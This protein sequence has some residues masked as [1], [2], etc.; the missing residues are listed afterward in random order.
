MA[1]APATLGALL[2]RAREILAAQG[3]DD[4]ALDARLIVE[5]FSGT[6]RADA[7]ARPEQALDTA[8]T[9]AI[10]AAIAR[11]RR[12]EPVHR[13]LG[14]REFY[15]LK[16][17]LSPATLEPRPDTET[18]VD[19]VLPFLRDTARRE[20][21]CRIL[22]LGTGTGA[23]A[24]A[25]LAQVENSTATG[26]DLAE[27]ALLTA[28]KNA[29]RLGLDSR[30]AAR[31]S[32]WFAEISGRFHLIVS[33]PPYIV[34]KEIEAL[35]A[36]VRD[37]DPLL[38]LDGGEDGL[39]AYRR[40]AAGAMAHLEPDGRIAVEIGYDQKRLVSDIFAEAGFSL[41]EAGRDLAGNDR[42]LIFRR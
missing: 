19:M 28:R 17:E 38:A 39:A 5:H 20:G 18:L 11:R 16:L 12:G 7:I 21:A 40:I 24:L 15:G 13:I 35:R 41:A 29:G 9:D 30:F 2:Q 32:D 6:T 37:F 26:V 3:I 42:V 34:T 31:K 1:D 10:E 25:L 36:D 23:I 8:A 33:N 22:D 27:G 4:A 14:F